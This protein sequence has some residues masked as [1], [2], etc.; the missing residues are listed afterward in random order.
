V[1]PRAAITPIA[2]AHRRVPNLQTYFTRRG[3]S[4]KV[5]RRDDVMFAYPVTGHYRCF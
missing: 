2:L 3:H 4:R 5:T 1:K